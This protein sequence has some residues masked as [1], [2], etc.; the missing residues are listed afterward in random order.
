M[1]TVTD[2]AKRLTQFFTVYLPH[3]RNVS[4]NTIDS[5][6]DAFIWFIEYMAQE[7]S[8]KVGDL[9]LSQLTYENV[10]G[11]LRWLMERRGNSASTRNYRLAAIHSF[12]MFLQYR[13]IDKM[14][15]WQKVLS[16][17]ALKCEKTQM[18]YL[19]TDGIK[20]LL[21]QPDQNTWQGRRHL[22][23][24]SLMY[25]TGARVQEIADIKVK[26]IRIECEPFSIV[27][28]GKGKKSRVVPL[29]KEEVVLLRRYVEENRLND[30]NML[31]HPLFY[32]NRGGK[33]TR[34]GIS[35][36][37]AKYVESARV[38]EPTLFADSISCHSIRHSRA[39]A[40]VDA[41][42][43]IVYIRDLLGH[44]SIQTTD[45]YARASSK[46]KREA[47]EAAY[48]KLTPDPDTKAQWET[49]KDLKEWLKSL[50]K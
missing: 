5:Y 35:H 7:K 41:G 46:S 28:H 38:E 49:D 3:D 25:D 21:A 47:F 11:F 4:P 24:L 48:K 29:A 23:I 16:I 50:G 10:L 33:L 36:I 2:F 14:E 22:A 26:D 6:K 44:V 15:Q 30:S 39:M 19:Q 31:D 12:V 40:L 45:I 27:L 18:N 34:Q 20:T 32:N 8:V 13:D 9:T 17:E 42:V 1:T 37:L 43:N